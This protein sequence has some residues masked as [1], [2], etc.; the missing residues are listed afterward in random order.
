MRI[1]A[2]FGHE[3]SDHISIVV[4][5]RVVVT[6]LVAVPTRGGERVVIRI[7]EPT[8]LALGE[9][10][11][12][13]S[14]R[15]LLDGLL[16]CPAALLIVS[17]P[18]SAGKS[19]TLSALAVELA[20]RGRS[21]VAVDGHDT[22]AS[23]RLPA[24]PVEPRNGLARAVDAALRRAPDVLVIDELS[25]RAACKAAQQPDVHER[26]TTRVTQYRA[27]G[28][29][30]CAFT[31]FRGRTGV[32]AVEQPADADGSARAIAARLREDGTRHVLA[33]LT[34][35]DEVVAVIPA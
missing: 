18:T 26:P 12:A 34:T 22:H 19:T 14:H 2:R 21:V 6:D 15:A 17:G 33:G 1:G 3:I 11:L 30:A 28:C 29:A 31:G 5:G 23:P 4:D 16:G 25:D 35:R 7:P 24:V 13:R 8:R 9:L 32:F 27:V 10:G 20:H